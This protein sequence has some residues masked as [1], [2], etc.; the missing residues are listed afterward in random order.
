[1]LKFR[2]P[3]RK[4]VRFPDSSDFENFPDFRTGC[5]VRRG[6]ALV[7]ESFGLWKPF[8]FLLFRNSI[9]IISQY[10]LPREINGLLANYFLYQNI[11]ND[12]DRFTT[13]K[14]ESE[15]KEENRFTGDLFL[16]CYRKLVWLHIE[17]QKYQNQYGIYLFEMVMR[18]TLTI[19]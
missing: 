2:H 18:F 11:Y 7:P 13:V 8:Y 19:I 3:G 16:L 5:D 4:N 15:V 12:Q 17:T 6:R 1:M 9:R 14:E 10:K